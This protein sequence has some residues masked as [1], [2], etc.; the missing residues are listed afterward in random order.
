MNKA[1]VTILIFLVVTTLAASAASTSYRYKS[2]NPVIHDDY[3]DFSEVP[4]F[5]RYIYNLPDTVKDEALEDILLPSPKKRYRKNHI[6][7]FAFKCCNLRTSRKLLLEN[8]K[9][10]FYKSLSLFSVGIDIPD[11]ISARGKTDAIRPIIDKMRAL[12]KRA[13]PPLLMGHIS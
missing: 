2:H 6:I 7:D 4:K 8:W 9:S 12:G 13:R 10:L 11:Y 5:L 1:V 3:D